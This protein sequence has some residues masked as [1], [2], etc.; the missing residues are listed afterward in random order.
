MPEAAVVGA[1]L[2]G[3]LTAFGLAKRGWTVTLYE[4]RPD[5]RQDRF[6][7]DR[8]RSI[9][10][11][12]SARGIVAIQ[13]VDP[14]LA[15]RILREVIP[16]RGRMIHSVDG[17]ESSQQ[18]SADGLV[19]QPMSTIPLRLSAF[20]VARYDRVDLLTPAQ[21]INSIDRRQLNATLLDE[22]ES[23]GA[24]RLQLRFGHKLLRADFDAR[25]RVFEVDG[26]RR[27][28]RADFVVGADGA[29]SRV[30]EQ[31]MRK[32]PLDFSQSYIPEI[33]IE[34]GIPAKSGGVFALD[35]H[36]CVG[37]RAMPD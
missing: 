9:N 3:C 20:A 22:C 24:D 19:R 15:E 14:A 11:A 27:T 12:L 23:L 37:A 25:T 31:L 36:Q 28:V 6:E 26:E 21:A 29:H 5:P 10:L 2:V 7:S 16:M 8:L 30:R 17:R 32:I 13:S 35:P 18:Y 33:Y 4:R 1:G 34:L